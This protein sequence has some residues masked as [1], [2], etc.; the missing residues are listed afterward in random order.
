[1]VRKPVRLANGKE[2]PSRGDAISYFR[3]LRDRYPV[4]APILDCSDHEDLLALLERYDLAITDGP[5]KIGAGVDHFETRINIT[6]GG[7]N[8]GFWAIR[9]DG[10]ETDFSFIRA[11]NETPK[12]ELEQLV[13]ACREA[14]FPEIQSAKN[15]YFAVHGDETGRVV[16]RLTGEAISLHECALE[17]VGARFS[18]LVKNYA[19]AQGWGTAIPAG[20]VSQPAD[21]QTESIF[22]SREHQ[23]GFCR[24]HRAVAK[25]RVVSK[26][27]R[28]SRS[29]APAPLI[30]ERFLEL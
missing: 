5:P 10:T 30:E 3:E 23:E 13:D 4:G 19:D 24:F 9:V 22:I 26:A 18:Q 11:V 14:V 17:Y 12:R 7:R 25:I 29:V 1:M 8:V 6:N 2:W 20:I 28:V 16:C 21:A 15:H 27:A